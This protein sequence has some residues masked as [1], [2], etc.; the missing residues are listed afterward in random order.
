MDFCILDQDELN[1]FK[2]TSKE[3]LLDYFLTFVKFSNFR[4]SNSFKLCLSGSFGLPF[5]SVVQE[6]IKLR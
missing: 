5:F 4:V 6:D 3:D 2:E 1:V